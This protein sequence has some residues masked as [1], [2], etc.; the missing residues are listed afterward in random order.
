MK[1]YFLELK[2]EMSKDEKTLL[3]NAKYFFAFSIVMIVAM[4]FYYSQT[5]D[6]FLPF[7]VL[8][9]TSAM[10]WM[11]SDKTGKIFMVL[12]ASIGFI[13]EVIGGMEGWFIYPSGFLFQTPIWLITGYAAMYWACYNLWKQGSKKYKLKEK[14]FN[15]L[16][17]A[18][19]V[20]VLVADATVASFRSSELAFDLAF[21]AL[22][23]YLFRKPSDRHLALITWLLV[24]FD[25][26]LG[27]LL[28][29]WQHYSPAGQVSTLLGQV[30]ITAPA[31][32]G[33]SFTGI[34]ISYLLFLWAS[35][36][37]AEFIIEKKKPLVKDI[38]IVLIALLI[39]AYA[40]LTTSIILTTL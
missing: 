15:I 4:L 37:F 35:L 17:I 11:H 22:I 14:N 19:I 6:E 1:R 20:L 8:G 24:S 2:K 26:V 21:M 32:T 31:L 30:D 9:L 18:L 23:L 25:E 39:K 3:R 34:T 36:R 12:A 10:F 38:I 40:W 28:G 27:F 5:H 16:A 29:A 33:F 13:H 7:V